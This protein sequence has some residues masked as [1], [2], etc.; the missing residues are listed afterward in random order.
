MVFDVLIASVV[1]LA[2]IAARRTARAPAARAPAPPAAGRGRGRGLGRG[3]GM[4]PRTGVA[5]DRDGPHAKEILRGWL[6]G[7]PNFQ[8]W[9]AFCSHKEGWLRTADGNGFCTKDNMR[10]NCH[11]VM[12]RCTRHADP[13]DD[14]DG[15]CAML[16]FSH[17]C[18]W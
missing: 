1:A 9:R 6:S 15:Q 2:L 17:C 10:R 14:C 13:N 4:E 11:A 5:F 12:A 3:R 7:N 18:F 8:E 16:S